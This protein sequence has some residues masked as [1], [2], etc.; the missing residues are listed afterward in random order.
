MPTVQVGVSISRLAD[1]M[2]GALRI[3]NLFP[4]LAGPIDR[5]GDLLP[6]I[7]GMGFNAIYLNPLHPAGFSGSLY[8][9]KTYDGLDPRIRG[10]AEASDETLLRGFLEAADQHGLRVIMDLV[11]NHTAKDAALVTEHP[12]WYARDQHG[13]VQSP[14]AVDPD[15]PSKRT[16]WGDLAELHWHGPACDQLA[17]YFESVV[18]R[19]AAMGFGGF[20]CDAAYKVPAAAWRR[21]GTAAR[22]VRPDCV[23]C[24]ETLGCTPDEV[25]ALAGAGFDYLF[26]SVKWWDGKAGWF[27]EQYE[28]Y[29]RIA[30]AIGFPESHDTDRLANELGSAEPEQIEA[31]YRRHYLMAAALSAGIMMPIGY[32]HGARKKLDVVATTAADV[33][34]PHFDLT[35]FIA[36]VNRMK[37]A[38]PALNEDGPLEKLEAPGALVAFAKWT[39]A[40]D[41]LVFILMHPADAGPITV[42]VS[43]FLQLVKDD[44]VDLTDATP[45][46]QAPVLT[47]VSLN[48]GEVRVLHARLVRQVTE[49]VAPPDSTLP[50][51][52][53][54]EAVWPEI[55]G[56]RFPSKRIDGETIEVWADIY[57]DGHDKIAAALRVRQPDS[58]HWT[59]VPMRHVDNDRWSGRAVLSGIGLAHYTIEAWTDHFASWRDEVG[60]KRAAGQALELELIEGRQLVDAAHATAEGGAEERLDMLRTALDGA[61]TSAEK[62]ELLLSEATAHAMALVPDKH[63]RVLYEPELSVVVDRPAARFSAWYEMFQRSQGTVPGRSATFAECAARL[64]EIRDLGFDVV[65][66]VP[67]HPIGEINRKGKDNNP[68]AAP[69][70]PGSPYAVGNRHGGHDAVDPELGTLDDFRAFQRAVRDHGMELAIDF[71]IQCAPDHPW[72]KQHPGWFRRRPDGSM[73]YAENPPKKYQDI[74]N[75]DFD[76]A[77][78]Q[79]LWQALLDIVLFWAKE[80][81]RIFRVDN[82]HTKPVAFWQWLIA[83]AKREYPDALFLAE[84]FTKPKMMARLA[85]AGFSQSYSYFT[86]RNTK[87]ELTE[88]LTEL[89]RGP[90]K[91]FFRP[92]F[93]ANTPD[94]LPFYLQESGRPGF[95]IRLVLA[96]TLSGSYGIYNGFELCEATAIPGR[97][98]Y[99]HSEKYEYKVWDWDRPGHIKDDI[100]KLNWFRRESPALQLFTNLTFLFASG[101]DVLFYMKRSVEPPETILVAVNL[102]PHKRVTAELA[103][104]ADAI[105][106]AADGT[107]QTV[108]LFSGDRVTW[109]GLRHAVSF[110]PEVNPTMVWRV[111]DGDAPEGHS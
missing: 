22:S 83:E 28:L 61:A 5:W 101:D 77:D 104:P 45:R 69:G 24:A 33:E 91:D 107:F 108:E 110:D 97:E 62:A 31:A 18:R 103:F 76:Q 12:D 43:P 44:I 10:A 73:R 72:L 64:P 96:A 70:E 1:R 81:V 75:V 50:P 66:L 47:D 86:W 34:P 14:Y 29:R 3:Y 26:N 49:A 25:R 41:D 79:A 82:P 100:R 48:A 109:N 105:R 46:H 84:A 38:I 94:I 92:N 42:P 17:T 57:R 39:M 8:A 93:F 60:K 4:L 98:E 67:H 99:A 88:Y 71:A 111:V 74:V 13:D 63:D 32:E 59:L 23:F 51:R 54:I 87:A 89:T 78:W 6:K 52:I 15:D 21:L 102:D 16:I 30:P 65:Y 106:L 19:Y 68:V 20:R 7:A 95:R 40:R 55:D 37:A 80:G 9:V 2:H 35:P 27:L 11:A 90:A 85:K 56:G 58:D 36:A 53:I